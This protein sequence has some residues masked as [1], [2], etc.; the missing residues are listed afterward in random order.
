MDQMISICGSD[1]ETCYCFEANMCTGCHACKGKV[2]H[3]PE[4]QECRIYHCCVTEHGYQSCL[5]CG[6]LPC[7]IWRE[8]RDPKFSDDEFEQN[9]AERIARLRKESI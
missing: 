7:H 9:I 5:E 6:K 1:C 2:F 3:C 4:G 8:T